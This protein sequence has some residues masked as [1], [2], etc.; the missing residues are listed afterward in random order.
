MKP[1]SQI[2]N[3]KSMTLKGRFLTGISMLILFGGLLSVFPLL[4]FVQEQREHDAFT[5][6]NK[7]LQMQNEFISEWQ[8]ELTRDINY[9]SELPE[10]SNA[11][12]S[13]Y[14]KLELLGNNRTL[15]YDLFYANR[16]GR[17]L[18]NTNPRAE[19]RKIN[20]Y[21]TPYFQ[22][23]MEWHTFTTGVRLI[24]ER[25]IRSIIF[26]APVT[27]ENGQ[28]GGI[29]AGI[30]LVGDIRHI[31]GDFAYGKTGNVYLVDKTGTV[32]SASSRTFPVSLKNTKLFQDALQRKNRTEPYLNAN[33]IESIGQYTWINGDEWVLI[34]EVSTAEI[35]QPF[36]DTLFFMS[37]ILLVIFVISYFF[38]RRLIGRITQPIQALLEGTTILRK[39]YYSHRI[40][41]RVFANAS[42]EFSELCG[43]YNDMARDLQKEQAL[44]LQAEEEMRR[45]NE[46]L[47]RLSFSDSLTGIGNRRFFDDMLALSWKKAFE[48]KEPISLLLLD[49]DFFKKYNDRYGHDTGD[50]ALQHVAKV[51]DEIAKEAGASAAR[52]GGEELAVILPPGVPVRSFKLAEQIRLA[53]ECLGILHEDHKNKVITVSIGGATLTPQPGDHPSLL[54]RKADEALYTSKRKGRARTTTYESV[55]L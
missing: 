4:I 18:Y 52:Y 7:S 12:K 5:N 23:G 47:R 27:N 44:R 39:G 50:R 42:K 29:L 22:E 34:S 53:V 54:I 28:F 16:N 19:T 46:Q 30:V 6:L 33:G 37:I 1:F 10:A 9:L 35:E 41:D 36:Q 45:T 8:D 32:L 31:V 25:N 17:I 55:T 49:I 43:A 48:Q 38:I 15:F 13:F 11:D 51:V 14:E 24:G 26:S 20:V 2:F 40:D 21:N 3:G